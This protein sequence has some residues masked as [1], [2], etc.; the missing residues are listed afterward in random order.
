MEKWEYLEALHRLIDWL[1]FR[2][3]IGWNLV[4]LGLDVSPLLGNSWLSGFIEAEG[5][6]YCGFSLNQY[7][8]A[9]SIKSALYAEINGQFTSRRI[10]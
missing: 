5:N 7:N 9:H 3:D 8:I 2:Q 6:F 10:T 1:N 4:K